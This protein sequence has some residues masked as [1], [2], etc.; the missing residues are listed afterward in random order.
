M[1]DAPAPTILASLRA[2]S[3]AP[4]G[5][6]CPGGGDP[7]DVAEEYHEAS[8][9]VAAF[10]GQA[11]GPAGRQLASSATAPFAL[12][13]KALTSTGPHIPLPSP[14]ALPLDLAAVVRRRRS[15]LPDGCAPVSL[16]A[17]GTVLGLSAG[18]DPDRPGLRMT[19]SGGAMYPLDVVLIAH[20]VTGLAPGGYVYDPLG[21]ALLP[22]GAV[23]PEDFHRRANAVTPPPQPSLTLAFVATFARTRAK[24]GLR[25][26]RFALLEAGHL[27]QAAL[28]LATALGLATLPW[29][30]FVDAAVDAQLEVDGLDRSCVYLLAVSA[31]GAQG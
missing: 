11:L 30:G 21:H 18:A 27:A 16:D 29:G 19:P 12:G 8:K 20:R 4:T 13:R 23:D 2:F 31:Q 24:Y 1:T 5:P 14:Q 26:Y 9:V 17:V 6:W 22:R 3:R 28:T 25:G 10:P 7:V 15:G